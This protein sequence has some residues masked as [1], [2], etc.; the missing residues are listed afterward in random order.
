M[1][2][3]EAELDPYFRP[4]SEPFEV[5]LVKKGVNRLQ[6]TPEDFKRVPVNAADP[7]SALE[8]PAVVEATKDGEWIAAQAAKAHVMTDFEHMARVRASTEKPLDRVNI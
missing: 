6:A 7:T 5:V 3:P 4:R 2:K 8:H 1:S